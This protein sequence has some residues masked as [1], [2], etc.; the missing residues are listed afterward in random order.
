MMLKNTTGFRALKKLWLAIEPPP[1]WRNS[2]LRVKHAHRRKTEIIAVG[3]ALLA[4]AG[5]AAD[6]PN[7]FAVNNL[8]GRGVNIGGALDTPQKEG[9]WGVTL[10]DEYFQVIK[11]AGFDSIRIPVRWNAHAANEPSYTIEPEFFKRIDW[12]ITNCLSRHLT[13]VLTTHHYDELYADPDG[14]KDKFVA[15]WKQIAERYKNGPNTL[16]FDPLMEAQDK[17]D[18]GKWN[19]LLNE[20]VATIRRSNPHR[21]VV[22]CAAGLSCIENLH[23]LELPKEDHNLI[24][25]IFYYAPQE[26]TQQGA[27][28]IQGYDHW[29]GTKWTGSE[30]EKQRI[31]KDFDI[32]SDW[33]KQNH[34][35]I[36]LNEFGTIE[37][38]DMASRARWTQSVAE[39]ATRRGFSFSYW[40]F[41]S[42]FGLYDPQ[43]KSWHKELLEAL[44]PPVAGLSAPNPAG[45]SKPRKSN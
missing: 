29:L 41:C 45:G 36:Y 2:T 15:I 30:N 10:Q 24:V 44:I 23:L 37:K 34:R 19:S 4:C 8:I 39:A 14:Q 31:A 16:V 18:A 26:F 28:W 12:A 17:L 21:T 35:P 40:E 9:E 5:V 6:A 22:I 43:A 42:V 3:M 7:A 13:A 33:A 27:S 11:D 38:A 20:T 32:A 25:S 1:G